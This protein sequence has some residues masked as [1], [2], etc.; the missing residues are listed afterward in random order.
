MSPSAKLK[1][2]LE[3][4]KAAL[5]TA[6]PD[7]HETDYWKWIAA[8]EELINQRDSIMNT[9]IIVNPAFVEALDANILK[10]L[11]QR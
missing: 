10:V 2:L 1:Q 8:V 11:G 6:Y 9:R 5:A 4:K 7:P 3:D